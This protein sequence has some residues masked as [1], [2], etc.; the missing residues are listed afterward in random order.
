[1]LRDGG[2]KKN[3]VKYRTWEHPLSPSYK[4]TKGGGWIAQLAKTGIGYRD[5]VAIALG[6]AAANTRR[7][8]GC[9]SKWRVRSANVQDARKHSRLLAA[10]YHMVNNMKARAFIESEMP[11]PG[12]D[13]ASAEALARVGRRLVAAAEIVAGA[14]RL[15]VRRA[16]FRPDAKVDSG[17]TLLV[18]V[19]ERFWTATQ[20]RFF[21]LL[22]DGPSIDWEITLG[23][24]ARTWREVLKS[25]ALRLFDAAA[26]LDPSA[27]SCN[28]MRIV[29]AKR[30]LFGTLEGRGSMGGKLFEELQLPSPTNRR[31]R[32]EATETA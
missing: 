32:T 16:H 15:A 1:L 23:A 17:S 13:P 6:D 3:G 22:P 27:A 26:P 28:P 11:L 30:N 24:A 5:W 21:A 2:N 25:T 18:S 14:L 4:D 20:D 8:A 19:Y 31:Q 10:G 7:P 29:E 12:P 9:V